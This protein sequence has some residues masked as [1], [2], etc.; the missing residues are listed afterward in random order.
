MGDI[1]QALQAIQKLVEIS[2]T[3]ITNIHKQRAEET[4]LAM[5]RQWELD[6]KLA[7]EHQRGLTDAINAVLRVARS[8]DNN[9]K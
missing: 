1:G 7:L 9:G 2:E 8:E 4:D 3:Q 5:Q 6:L